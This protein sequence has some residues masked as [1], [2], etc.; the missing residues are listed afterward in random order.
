MP[1]RYA[2]S[3]SEFL[4]VLVL[5]QK[6]AHADVERKEKAA[7]AKKEQMTA[8]VA[9]RRT[10]L[11]KMVVSLQQETKAL[12]EKYKGRVSSLIP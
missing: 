10:K 3:L 12:D 2:G 8:S 11:R 1:V 7:R 9:E 6:E 5:L 4:S